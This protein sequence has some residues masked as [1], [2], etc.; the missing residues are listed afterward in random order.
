MARRFV[1][2][3]NDAYMLTNAAFV[4]NGENPVLFTKKNQGG[5]YALHMCS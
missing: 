5:W 4:N 2:P 1:S 3:D